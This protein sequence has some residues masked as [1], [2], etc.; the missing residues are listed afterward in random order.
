MVVGFVMLL[1]FMNRASQRLAAAIGGV[2]F[3]TFIDEVG[4]F[5]TQD[6]D[7][8]YQPSFALMYVVF[9]LLSVAGHTILRRTYTP[10]ECLL[11]ALQEVEE[12]ALLDFDVH[13]R[14][15]ALQLLDRSDPEHPLVGHLRRIVLDAPIVPGARPGHYARTRD[16]LRR[17]YDTLANHRRFQLGIIL[18]FVVQLA[19]RI[20]QVIVVVFFPWMLPSSVGGEVVHVAERLQDLQLADWGQLLSTAVSGVLIAAG[21]VALARSRRLAYRLFKGSVLITV[22]ITQ[23]FM[24]YEEQLSAMIG[25]G[26]NLLLLGA[27]QAGLDLERTRPEPATP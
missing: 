27:L 9:V 16:F 17:H 8:F 14:G 11:N 7:Y 25:L 19:L 13:E 26:L 12:L 24:F 5:V 6:N 1:T 21:V 3:G 4:K 20:G 18:F 15:R 10:S 2:G 22:F 23:F